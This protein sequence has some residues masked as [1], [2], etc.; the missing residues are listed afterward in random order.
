MDPRRPARRSLLLAAVLALAALTSCARAPQSSASA[1]SP[2]EPL[3]PD[4]EGTIA[5][6]DR[7]EA[8]L[9]G[10]IGSPGP[11]GRA[12]AADAQSDAAASAAPASEPAEAKAEAAGEEDDDEGSPTAQRAAPADP[13]ETACRALASMRRAA[14]HLC[15]LAGEQ[16]GRCAAARER[17]RG[18][19]E[20]V[21]AACPRCAG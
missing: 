16:D 7:A 11:G 4:V 8:E 17:V 20:R 13:C 9:A 18:A 21:R 19:D 1:K 10:A 15:G 5:L 3:P 2:D 6:L 12:G 14:E